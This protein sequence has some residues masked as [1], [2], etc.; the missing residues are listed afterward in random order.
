MKAADALFA[1]TSAR[2]PKPE[3]IDAGSPARDGAQAEAVEPSA[4]GRRILRALEEPPAAQPGEAEADLPRRRGR[5]PG[6]KNR[7]KPLVSVSADPSDDSIDGE[8]LGEVDADE[9]EADG[10]DFVAAAPGSSGQGLALSRATRPYRPRDTDRF[11]WVRTKLKPGEQWKRRLPKV[12][13]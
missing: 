2:S 9:V 1:P 6:S 3:L 11:S 8:D 12:C 4:S 7:P 13:W 5:K 10:F